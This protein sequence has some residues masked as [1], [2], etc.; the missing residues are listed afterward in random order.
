M[1]RITKAEL[2]K[3]NKELKQEIERLTD[4]LSEERGWRDMMLKQ[5][6]EAFS[7][8]PKESYLGQ[9][10]EGIRSTRE[11]FAWIGKVVGGYDSIL[12]EVE[13]LRE[14]V[15]SLTQRDFQAREDTKRMKVPIEKNIECESF[16]GMPRK[17]R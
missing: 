1:S 12:S 8:I 9:R 5:F 7:L 16:K 17:L 15:A 4:D 2:E 3:E 14:L 13:Y 6:S 11:M 10:S